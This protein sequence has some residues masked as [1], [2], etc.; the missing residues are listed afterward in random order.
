MVDPLSETLELL[1]ARCSIGGGMRAGGEWGLRFRP[2]VPVKLEAVVRGACWL[3]TED[4][5]PARLVPGD[6]VVLNHA[7][8]VVLCSDPGVRPIDAADLT[9]P[10]EDAF[11]PLGTGDDV[12]LLAGHVDIDPAGAAFFRAAL[13]AVLHASA[14]TPEAQEMRRLLERIVDETEGGRPGARFAVDQHAQL[15]LLETLRVGLSGEALS[16]PSW[17]RL[18]SDPQLRPAVTLI[19]GD[20]ARAWSLAELAAAVGMSR[21][22]F[23]YRFRSVSGQPPLTYLAHWRARLAQRALRDSDVTVATLAGRLGF[24]SESSFSHAFTRVVGTS[25]GRYRRA[26]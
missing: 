19:H 1:G 13:P 20:P 7:G 10:R 8:P 18:L 11:L 22:H 24:A 6:V 9:G 23:S 15:L 26:A 25:P 16:E 5:P 14:G 12:L 4:D 17:L 3:L 21:S 2:D